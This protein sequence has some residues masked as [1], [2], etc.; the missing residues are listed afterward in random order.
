M[1]ECGKSSR[2][3]YTYSSERLYKYQIMSEEEMEVMSDFR[4]TIKKQELGLGNRYFVRINT[5]F[6]PNSLFFLSLRCTSFHFIA[7]LLPF[8]CLSHL[9]DLTDSGIPFITLCSA[10]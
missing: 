5:R 9:S 1:A 10:F 6:L 7:L 3:M 2:A 8:I 4:V